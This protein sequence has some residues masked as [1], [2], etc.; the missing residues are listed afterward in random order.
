MSYKRNYSRIA[1]S[2]HLSTSKARPQNV[3][4]SLIHISL[5]ARDEFLNTRQPAALDRM[6]AFLYRQPSKQANR[7]GRCI[8]PIRHETFERDVCHAR[9]IAPWQKQTILMWFRCV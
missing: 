6:I 4:L 1:T 3:N 2:R 9:R 8:V 7:A 5:I